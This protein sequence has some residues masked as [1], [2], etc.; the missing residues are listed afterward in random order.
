MKYLIYVVCSLIILFT[1]CKS[2][3][4]REREKENKSVKNK[5]TNDFNSELI[6]I[7][8]SSFSISSD[9]SF[10]KYQEESYFISYESFVT[11]EF[12][13]QSTSQSIIFSEIK[14]D[15]IMISKE[16]PVKLI[17]RDIYPIRIH[18]NIN[19]SSSDYHPSISPD[20]KLLFFTG[21]DRTGYFDNKID[22]TKTKNAG[23]ED[24][25]VSVQKSG[26]W[27]E[28]AALK[29]VN[30]NGH[31]AVTQ[32]LSNGDL[33]LSGNFPE[34]MGPD[35]NSNGSNTCDLFM[36]VKNKNYQLFHFDEP[37]NSIYSELD[38]Y[39]SPDGKFILFCSDRPNPN[40]KYH[41]KGWLWN[42]SY[43]GNTDIYVS[44]KEGDSWSAPKQLAS[45]INT[46]FT[47]RTPWLSYDGLTLFFSSNGY[48][49]D[50]KDLD[51]YFFTRKS[52]NDWDN[53]EGPYEITHLN[54]PT[55]DWGYQEDMSGNGF[56]ARAVK[57]GYTPTKKA[58]DGTG[59]VFETNFRS[60]YEIYGL[61]S[62][63]FQKDEQT[64]IFTVNRNNVAITLPDILFDVDSYEL[65]QAFKEFK[66]TIM[67]YIKINNPKI[68][69]I[70]G[71]T[72]SDGKET[73]NN[74]LSL[75]RAISV[76]KFIE[77]EMPGLNI[78]CEGKG[79]REPVASNANADGKRKNRRVEIS[80]E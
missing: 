23:G 30:T 41:K 31:E 56:F 76:K 61:Q 25:F 71:H 4:K 39:L 80:F 1:N 51:I 9:S 29:N 20:G 36:A 8:D 26:I 75:N 35:E 49:Q 22:F 15:K 59:F 6:E 72:D 66:N 65:S 44:F 50:K 46:D 45:G 55:D 67:D 13:E 2:K 48:N 32:C 7:F 42:E 19:T 70:E 47:E 38:G 27:Q 53:W 58:K 21:M 77:S 17:A 3:A 28:A 74:T 63:S 24:I 73:H 79:S 52:K 12:Y 33:M 10:V 11:S 60:G 40:S 14:G 69:L 62:A 37:V 16:T 54:G 43:W 34:N 68:I 57:L 64:E 18:H 5:I 78:K